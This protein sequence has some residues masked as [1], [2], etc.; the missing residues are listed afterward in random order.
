MSLSKSEEE[1]LKSIKI[2][3]D[4]DPNR[5]EFPPDKPKYPTTPTYQIKVPGFKNVWLKDESVNPTGTH[6]DRMAWEIIVQYRKFLE[7]KKM[8]HVNGPLPRFSIISSGNAAV[9]LAEMFKKFNLPKVKVLVDIHMPDKIL[10]YLKN[11]YC[12]VYQTN[13]SRK[14]FSTEEVLAMTNNENGFDITSNEALDPNTIFYDWMS[15]DIINKEAD[16]VFVPFGTGSLFENICTIMRREILKVK[17]HDPRL[18]AD[19]NKFRTMNILG[20]TVNLSTSNAYMLYSQHLPF[21]HYN[22]QWIRFYKKFGFVGKDSGVYV[23]SEG[24]LE[25]AYDLAISQGVN[26]EH[27]GIAG[28]ALLLDRK[29]EI[30]NSK[31]IVIVNTGKGRWLN[32]II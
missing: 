25:E 15:Y 30:P 14:P 23:V 12:E 8:G 22:E 27:S 18:E 6:K 9:A 16:Y 31:K 28:L 17:V 21:V 10:N 20:A 3:S 7:A 26:C 24:S 29:N 19:T 4:N 32:E 5:P 13:L 11:N 1:I 2:R